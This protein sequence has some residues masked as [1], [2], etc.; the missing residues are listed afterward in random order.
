MDKTPGETETLV[1]LGAL[2]DWNLVRFSAKDPVRQNSE[3][4]LLVL[5]GKKPEK[6]VATAE[7]EISPEE[8]DSDPSA[9]L[10][11]LEI[12]SIR[13]GSSG[14]LSDGISIKESYPHEVV[15]DDTG[16]EN[17][18]WLEPDMCDAASW[19]S[20]T[21]G[22][23]MLSETNGSYE[24]TSVSNLE[25]IL[26]GRWI[27]QNVIEKMPRGSPDD[28]ETNVSSVA[29]F[30]TLLTSVS[31]DL[32]TNRNKRFFSE[33]DYLRLDE[34]LLS[35]AFVLLVC[36]NLAAACGEGREPPPVQFFAKRWAKII[37]DLSEQLSSEKFSQ[38]TFESKYNLR[39]IEHS[40]EIRR[41]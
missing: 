15:L 4:R 9:T 36:L 20:E 24:S 21:S 41:P 2:N 19:D 17:G 6:T 5:P 11:N 25:E 1:K 27:Q 35:E 3:S 29:N 13:S 8:E 18:A 32:R 12:I 26:S 37:C 10:N 7:A 34:T 14:V 33:G 38:Q 16:S 28:S 23:W 40:E 39:W 31:S 30:L 22:N